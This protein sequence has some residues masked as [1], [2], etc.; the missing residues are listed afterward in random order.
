MFGAKV[1]HLA[2]LL[3]IVE[4]VLADERG[5]GALVAWGEAR[6][7]QKHKIAVPA[8]RR[9]LLH[10]NQEILLLL[11]QNRLHSLELL[12]LLVNQLPLLVHALGSLFQLFLHCFFH[13]LKC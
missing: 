1:F 11:R 4:L 10:L 5:G 2:L 12:I 9:V 13:D 8:C 7:N 3:E 6:V